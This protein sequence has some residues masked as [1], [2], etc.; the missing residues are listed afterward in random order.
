MA[1]LTETRGPGS[2]DFWSWRDT[3]YRFASRM[4]PAQ[5]QAVASQA[6]LEMLEAGFTRHLP[7]PVD[8]GQLCGAIRTLGRREVQA[9]ELSAP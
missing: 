6:Y 9:A 3:M 4:T 8:L 1:G 2:D 7:K 5:L